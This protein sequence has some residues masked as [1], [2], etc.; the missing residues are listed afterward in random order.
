[1]QSQWSPSKHSACPTLLGNPCQD[2][3]RS[4]H[5][6]PTLLKEPAGEN[7]LCSKG[8][9]PSPRFQPPLFSLSRITDPHFFSSLSKVNETN[10]NTCHPEA[11]VSYRFCCF[12]TSSILAWIQ[13]CF[14]RQSNEKA[15]PSLWK[16]K[17]SVRHFLPCFMPTVIPK[18][19]KS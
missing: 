9:L 5:Q 14:H 12:L 7:K 1:M 18:P 3:H 2:A 16:H 19:S 10:V 8:F 4:D 17:T 13:F 15:F 6:C 11:T